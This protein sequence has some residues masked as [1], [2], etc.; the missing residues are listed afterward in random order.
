MEKVCNSIGKQYNLPNGNTSIH[1]ISLLTKEI[2]HVTKNEYPSERVIVYI[3][4][5]L[6]REKLVKRAKDIRI[7][8]SQRLTLWEAG[9]ID[10]LINDA[11]SSDKKLHYT[12][13][14]NDGGS[15]TIKVFN[16]L[17]LR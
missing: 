14:K 17:M 13:R 11:I 10:S 5:I 12:M 15:E 8:M 16:R 7:L 6:Q 3:S 2:E 4:V 1:F 9:E